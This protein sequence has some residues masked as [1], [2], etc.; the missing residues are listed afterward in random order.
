MA[1]RSRVFDDQADYYGNTD[2]LSQEEKEASQ[3]GG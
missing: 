1:E 3:R 2:W